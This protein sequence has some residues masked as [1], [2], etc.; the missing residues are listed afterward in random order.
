VHSRRPGPVRDQRLPVHGRTGLNSQYAGD[1]I[2]IIENMG[3]DL[4]A[5]SSLSDP[6]SFGVPIVTMHTCD[7]IQGSELSSVFALEPFADHFRLV[8]VKWS[9]DCTCS[10]DINGDNTNDDGLTVELAGTWGRW[11]GAGSGI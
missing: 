6:S 11:V 5:G 8:S 10:F 4:C 9:D 7:W 2:V 3:S 1:A